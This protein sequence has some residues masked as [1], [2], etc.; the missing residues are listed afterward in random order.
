MSAKESAEVII[1]VIKRITKWFGM[2]ILAGIL[3][4]AVLYAYSEISNYFGYEIYKNKVTIS[5]KFDRKECEDPK[6]PM[7]VMTTNESNK[8]LLKV[9]FHVFVTKKGHSSKINDYQS[10]DMDRILRNNEG[11]SSCY[12]VM[13]DSYGEPALNGIDMDVK[14]TD[15][16]VTFE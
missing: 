4:G 5:A 6:F 14:I 10:Y 15:Y 1:L 3:I 2:I 11:F 9:N 7:F 13:P 8:K 12:S 16:T